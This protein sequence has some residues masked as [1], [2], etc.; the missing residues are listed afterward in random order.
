MTVRHWTAPH[1]FQ[2]EV[3]LVT[4][5]TPSLKPLL[6]VLLRVHRLQEFL[7]VYRPECMGT[8]HPR[9]ARLDL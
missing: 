8:G 4:E 1:L 9:R 6:E 7:Q 5:R 3:V 2:V